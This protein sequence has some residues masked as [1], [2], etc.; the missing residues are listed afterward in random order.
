MIIAAIVGL[1]L[2]T[3]GMFA[4]KRIQ[5]QNTR[6]TA[7]SEAQKIIQKAQSESAK[8]KKDSELK[9][10]DFFIVWPLVKFQASPRGASSFNR[11]DPDCSKTF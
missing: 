7:Q 4:F 11:P 10:K 2:G 6:K 9:S 1:I 8:I 3:F 5:E